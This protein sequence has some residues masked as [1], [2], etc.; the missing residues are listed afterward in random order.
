MTAVTDSWVL[1]EG[2][3]KIIDSYKHIL[4]SVAKYQSENWA[5]PKVT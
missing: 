1:I 3:V 5:L 4:M 2:V